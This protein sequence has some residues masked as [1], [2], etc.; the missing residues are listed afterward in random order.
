MLRREFLLTPL[1]AASLAGQT[2]T[3]RPVYM[4][5]HG[6]VATGHY[7]TAMAGFRM[8]EQGGNAVD[9]AAA[10]ALASTVVEPSRAGIGGHAAI[11]LYLAR[12]KRIVYI[13][14]NGWA[15]QAA[16][17]ERFANGGIPMDGPLAPVVP[18]AVDGLLTAAGKYGKLKPPALLAPAIDLAEHGFGTSE[19]MQNVF[20]RNAS[21]LDPHPSTVAFWKA[22]GEWPRMGQH[23][24]QKDLAATFRRIAQS[25]RDGFYRG[26]TAR[27]I[28]GFLEA[29]GG[30]LT[31]A[32]LAGFTAEETEPLHIRY[33]DFDLYAAPPTSYAHVM[34]ESLKILEGLDLRG[35]GHNSPAYLHHVAEAMKI[36]FADRDTWISDPRFPHRADVRRLLTDAYAARQRARIRPDSVLNPNEAHGDPLNLTASAYPDWIEGLTTYCGVIDREGNMA[37]VTSTIS[38]D[39]GNAQYVDGEGGGFFLNNWMSLFR[40]EPDHPNCIAPGKRP[41]HGLSPCLALRGGE[42]VMAFGTPGGDTIPQSQLQFF[43][44]TAE[45]GMNLQQA[46]EQPYALTSAFVAS[47]TPHG[48][49]NRLAVSERIE[50]QVRAGLEKRGHRVTTHPAFGVGG[51]KAVARDPR[52]I[53]LGGAA[54]ATDS[55][56][57]GW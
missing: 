3:W 20:Q 43:L 13:N 27:R 38:S 10:A 54:P 26:V 47:R 51:V 2:S 52:G 24:V 41:R 12:E 5:R 56:I 34:L 14:G 19:N 8:L 46:V 18:G 15:P 1:A 30:I 50:N 49:G 44:N 55:Y 45:F 9:A 25:G 21:R 57:A 31:E 22:G 35:M 48:I 40:V 16:T 42:A 23:I 7:M 53:L 39:F 4:A 32:D 6:I 28:A 11:L 17:P 36:S 33:K 29:Q 37:S